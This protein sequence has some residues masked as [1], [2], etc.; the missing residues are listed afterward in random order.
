[1]LALIIAT[2]DTAPAPLSGRPRGNHIIV[3]TYFNIHIITDT[4]LP[5]DKSSLWRHY[6]R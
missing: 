6:M 2:P 1:M 3:V 5:T 4:L